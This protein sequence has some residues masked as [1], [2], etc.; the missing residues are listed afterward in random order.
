MLMVEFKDLA[1]MEGKD[2]KWDAIYKKVIGDETTEK[3]LRES[4]VS[5][6]TIYGETLLR[7]VIY[8]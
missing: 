2:D 1:S 3:Q 8:K 5:Q 4:R 6:R 7:E